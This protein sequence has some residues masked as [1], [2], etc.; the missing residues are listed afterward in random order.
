MIFADFDTPS[1]VQVYF[2]HG[3]ITPASQSGAWCRRS[4]RAARCDGVIE[5][6]EPDLRTAIAGGFAS[7]DAGVN[8]G[9]SA[10][11]AFLDYPPTKLEKGEGTTEKPDIVKYGRL[12]WREW[13]LTGI[14]RLKQAGIIR[15]LGPAEPAP[16]TAG[17]AQD[18]E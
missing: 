15:R 17:V 2:S 8:N 3:G 4:S 6:S 7:L 14:P 1:G 11:F 18:G 16:D 5:L 13:S 10:G 9:G 12:E